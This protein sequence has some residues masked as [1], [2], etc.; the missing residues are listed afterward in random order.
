MN[1]GHVQFVLNILIFSPIINPIRTFTNAVHTIQFIIFSAI[2]LLGRADNGRT[3]DVDVV[4]T[5]S[6]VEKEIATGRQ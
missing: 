1:A 5:G 3:Y 6:F 2:P 4:P